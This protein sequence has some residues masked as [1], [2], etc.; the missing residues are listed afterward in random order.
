MT[1]FQDGILF[2]YQEVDK[3]DRDRATQ[4]NIK[5]HDPSH[6]NNPKSII[7]CA[8]ISFFSILLLPY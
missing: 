7:C 5:I 6:G 3:I 4:V 2:Q 8:T 1:R